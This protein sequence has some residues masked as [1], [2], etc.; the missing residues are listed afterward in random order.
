MNKF[1]GVGLLAVLILFGFGGISNAATLFTPPLE[2]DF[3]D[4]PD[5][6]LVCT[7]TNVSQSSRQIT[8]DIIN[9]NGVSINTV[10]DTV[11][12]GARLGAVQSS[13][14]GTATPSHCKF[15][16][17]NGKKSSVRAS[18]CIFQV[19]IGCISALPAS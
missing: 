5:V 13:D 2:V 19:G 11:D 17:K 10:T 4:S 18:A 1:M 16:I 14:N 15:D 6:S 8:I 12:P 9:I 3:A 7:V